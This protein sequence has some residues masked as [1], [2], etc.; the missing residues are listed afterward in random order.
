MFGILSLK[1]KRIKAQ[2][3]KHNEFVKSGL[4]TILQWVGQ[5]S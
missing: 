2:R 1:N 5:Q 3:A 4:E